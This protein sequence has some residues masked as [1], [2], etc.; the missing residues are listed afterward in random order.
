MGRSTRLSPRAGTS[1]KATTTAIVRGFVVCQLFCALALSPAGPAAALATRAGATVTVAW[2]GL[3]LHTVCERL[4]TLLGRPVIL[5]RRVDPGVPVSLDLRDAPADEALA[6]LCE[7][8]GTGCV[9]LGNSIRIVPPGL[10]ARVLAAEES[11][12][13]AV[14]K[15]P[16][17]LRATAGAM[18]PRSWDDGATPRDLLAD[19]AGEGGLEL[20]GL[21]AFPHD[22]LRGATLPP[23]PLAERLDL[24]LLQYDRRLDWSGARAAA[25]KV[26][27]AIV[28]CDDD[29]DDANGPAV[30]AAAGAWESL[31]GTPPAGAPEAGATWSLEVAAPLDRLLAAVAG[32]LGL[33]LDLDTDGLERRGVAA[34]G[35]VRLSVKE[36]SRDELLDRIA[37][38]LGLRWT[39]DGDTLRVG[40][41][42]E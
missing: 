30:V 4:S 1:S 5:D 2:T 41:A 17:R 37:D 38:P 28:P 40:P 36:V 35:I 15:L 21:D 7:A 10:P 12:R 33:R 18:A 24:L 13:G 9:V 16:A 31:A 6:A 25:G 11:R 23:L 39:I 8:A 32:K 20:D 14:K 34:G 42:G 22:H 3:P 26:R 19:L 27:V 29:D